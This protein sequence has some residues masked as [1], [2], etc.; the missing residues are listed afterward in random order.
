MYVAV[1][2]AAIALSSSSC[3]SL[4]A[5][6]ARTSADGGESVESTARAKSGQSRSSTRSPSSSAS[7]ATSKPSTKTTAQT[8]APSETQT[9]APSAETTAPAQ[10]ASGGGKVV[11]ERARTTFYQKSNNDPPGSDACAYIP[12]CISPTQGTPSSAAHSMKVPSIYKKGALYTVHGEGGAKPM[13]VKV[14]DLCA[15]CT[16]SQLDIYIDD[17]VTLPFDYA[18]ITEGC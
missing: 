10:A 16:S 9:S 2:A 3:C 4:S 5:W 14:D 12:H 18:K 8:S 15:G 11:A 1:A 17:G 13:C 6:R 7:K